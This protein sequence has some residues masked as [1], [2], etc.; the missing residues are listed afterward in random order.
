[1]PFYAWQC[2][3]LQ[4]PIRSIDLVIPDE[5]DMITLLS[6]LVWKTQTLNGVA[7]TADRLTERMSLT[8]KQ[9]LFSRVMMKFKVMKI[10]MKIS[11]HAF[12]SRITI[13]ELFYRQILK[14]YQVFFK[15]GSYS[16]NFLQ[17]FL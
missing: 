7:G 9:E 17:L 3:T 11:F 4:L 15:S 13:K 1:M 6:L 8:Q 12:E 2:L 5:K 14:T 16:M 10:R